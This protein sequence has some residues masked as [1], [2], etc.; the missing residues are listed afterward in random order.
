MSTAPLENAPT[1]GGARFTKI[2]DEHGKHIITRD[3]H[4]ELEWTAHVIDGR[5]AAGFGNLLRRSGAEKVCLELTLGGHKDWRLPELKEGLSIGLV[6]TCWPSNEKW[7]W[8]CTPCEQEPET[9]A[10]AFKFGTADTGIKER[11]EWLHVR[12]VRGQMR[13]ITTDTPKAGE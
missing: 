3:A 4:T 11:R 2:Y 9:K 10:W 1:T 7:L 12:A 6:D 8:T 13:T 5:H